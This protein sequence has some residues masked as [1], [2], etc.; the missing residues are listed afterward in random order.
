MTG[1]N[2]AF[3]LTSK[4]SIKIDSLSLPGDQNYYGIFNE[5]NEYS[6]LLLI[7]RK[8]KIVYSYMMY[9]NFNPDHSFITE[10]ILPKIAQIA[11]K[12]I[13]EKRLVLGIEI[14]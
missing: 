11:I 13:F 6:V 10:L 5:V 8:N 14:G 2:I 7:I 1:F 9:G 3:D 12:I 4:N